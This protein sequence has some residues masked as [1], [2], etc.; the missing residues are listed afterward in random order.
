MT[1]WF[2]ILPKPLV[3]RHHFTTSSC[4]HSFFKRHLILPSQVLARYHGWVE[5]DPLNVAGSR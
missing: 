4:F 3:P 2:P 5:L 1:G